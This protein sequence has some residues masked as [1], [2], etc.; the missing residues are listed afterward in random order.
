MRDADAAMYRAKARGAPLRVFDPTH[1]RRRASTA[2]TGTELRPRAAN[3]TSSSCTTS[4]WSPSPTG[5]I[6]GFE[7]LVRW[8]HPER[9][10]LGPDEFIP[11]PRTPA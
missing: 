1:A 9:G 3:A 6:V 11:S 8:N 5:A 10:L 4:R 2:R 7:A